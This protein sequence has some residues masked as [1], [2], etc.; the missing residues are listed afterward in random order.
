MRV[1]IAS[2]A[3]FSLPFPKQDGI[4]DDDG[5]NIVYKVAHSIRIASI[6]FY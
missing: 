2:R 5:S 4:F 3:Y 6:R 1:L